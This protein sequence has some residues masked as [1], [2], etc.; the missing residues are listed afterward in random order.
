MELKIV[1][2]NNSSEPD[3][4]YVRLQALVDLNANDYAVTDK[5]FDQD[6]GLSNEFRHFYRFP[7]VK[8]KKGEFIRLFT[9]EGTYERHIQDNDIVV[10]RFYWNSD[11]CVWNDKEQDE[12]FVFKI[13]KQHS[14]KVGP[15][16]K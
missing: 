2:V 16:K 15:P 13:I 5:S 11:E 8:V 3:K 10:H 14:F 9:G 4:E 1:G 6:G 12:A 7:P